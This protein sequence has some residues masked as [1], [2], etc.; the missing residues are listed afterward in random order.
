MDM[1]KI[2]LHFGPNISEDVKAY[3]LQQTTGDGRIYRSNTSYVYVLIPSGVRPE[4]M[5]IRFE[6]FNQE[7]Q[8][9]DACL[10]LHAIIV[11]PKGDF[12]AYRWEGTLVQAEGERHQ[13][14]HSE[15]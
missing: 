8:I 12:K 6:G 7:F 9:K 15:E 13:E 2:R 5:P 3:I 10:H 11:D 1:I 14:A 4:G